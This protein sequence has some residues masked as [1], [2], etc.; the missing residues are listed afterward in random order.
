M[1]AVTTKSTAWL[2]TAEICPSPALATRS[3]RPRRRRAELLSRGSRGK[4]SSCLFQLLGA[5]GSA[6]R[7]FHLCLCLHKAALDY[8][9]SSVSVWPLSLLTTHVTGFR[10][11]LAQESV[12]S[13]S[14]ICYICKGPFPRSGP[15]HVFWGK[16]L[17]DVSGA[18]HPTHNPCVR[19][20]VR[21]R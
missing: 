6:G 17:L 20:A 18:H 12:S 7:P 13:K 1:V 2:T 3:L 9:P 21:P 19:E 15:V 16:P 10:A 8:V 14:F 4:G 11:T 5:C